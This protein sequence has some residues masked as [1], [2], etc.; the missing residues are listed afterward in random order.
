MLLTTILNQARSGEVRNLSDK[1]KTDAILIDYINMSLIALY[2]RFSVSTDEAILALKTGKTLY[3]LGPDD[4]DVTVASAPMPVDDV[5][6]VTSAYDEIGEELGLNDFEDELGVFTPTYNTVQVPYSAD[7]AYVSVIYRK[8]PILLNSSD[9]CDADGKL[10]D[11]T[12]NVDLPLQLLE[13]LLHYMGYRA[14]GA[15]DALINTE[16]NTH[17]MRYEA[18]CDRVE[19]LGAVITDRIRDRDVGVKGFV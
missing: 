19:R 7:D 10:T 16:N 15:V 5:L 17:Y 8:N 1:D 12:V 14:H 9:I 3:T 11:T 4:P 6:V 18:S 13:P 2:A